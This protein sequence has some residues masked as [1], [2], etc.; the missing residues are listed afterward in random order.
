MILHRNPFSI[1]RMKPILC[2]ALYSLTCGRRSQKHVS[3]R[4]TS[5]FDHSNNKHNPSSEYNS[6][7][8]KAL[9]YNDLDRIVNIARGGGIGSVDLFFRNYPYIAAFLVC[10]TKASFADVVA[11]KSNFIAMRQKTTNIATPSS[12]YQYISIQITV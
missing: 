4:S 2:I 6:I 5:S 1:D 10:A 9:K 11:Q 8:M 7:S 3:P 12:K